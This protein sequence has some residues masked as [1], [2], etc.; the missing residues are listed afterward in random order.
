MTSLFNFAFLS[1]FF[2]FFPDCKLLWDSHLHLLLLELC[3]TSQLFLAK[4]YVNLN[5]LLFHSYRKMETNYVMH[6]VQSIEEVRKEIQ[7]KISGMRGGR[8]GVAISEGICTTSLQTNLLVGRTAKR[9]HSHIHNACLSGKK[10]A[11]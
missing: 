1:H 8:R 2:I 3:K 9:K 6:S 4:G 10:I 11:S 7:Q 5:V